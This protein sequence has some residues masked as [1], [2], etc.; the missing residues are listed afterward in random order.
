[1]AKI[2]RICSVQDCGK[3]SKS[4]GF[5]ATHYWRLRAHGHPMKT[6][7][8]PNGATQKFFEDVV[9]RYDG[10]ECLTWPYAKSRGYGE[11][12]INGRKDKVHIFVCEFVHGMRPTPEH[13]AAHSCGK[14]HEGCCAKSHLSW[15]TA[16]ENQQDRRIHGTYQLGELNPSNKLMEDDVRQIILLKGKMLQKEIAA[17]FGVSRENISAIHRGKSWSHLR[18]G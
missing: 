4:L 5:C 12:T 10:V 1:M 17:M 7:K 14:G 11:A 3:P 2:N 15:K 18:G 16:A 13:E 9:L 6:K 8:L